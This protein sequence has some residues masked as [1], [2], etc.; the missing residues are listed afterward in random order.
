[1][2]REE[3]DERMMGRGERMKDYLVAGDIFYS[4]SDE[5]HTCSVVNQRPFL[6]R[7]PPLI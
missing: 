5:A 4:S 2:K 6:T 1:M 3:S 7:H